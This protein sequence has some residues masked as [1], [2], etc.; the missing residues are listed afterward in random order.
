MATRQHR[1][2]K[3]A[4]AVI[5]VT[6]CFVKAPASADE[7]IALN[8]GPASYRR[9]CCGSQVRLILRWF[10]W[11]FLVAEETSV[12][13]SAARRW[14]FGVR[15]RRAEDPLLIVH[16]VRDLCTTNLFGS[17]RKLTERFPAI[18]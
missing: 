4:L 11:S 9:L 13:R 2:T 5:A 17:V 18:V 12:S 1:L 7:V 14:A 8:P 6:L 16:H 15:F 3:V 10:S